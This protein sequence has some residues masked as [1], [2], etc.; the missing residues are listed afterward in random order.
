MKKILLILF[1]LCSVHAYS[2]TISYGISGGPNFTNFPGNGTLNLS[3]SN[4]YITGFHV[5]G[6]LD[7]KFQSFS[8]QP[9]ILFTTTGGEGK[10]YFYNGSNG[11]TDYV[12]NKIVLDYIEVP[13]NFLYRI[14][15]DNGSVFLGGG[16]YFSF[17]V[18][19]KISYAINKDYGTTDN[20]SFGNDSSD[21]NVLDFGV[22]TLEGYQFDS[23][24][25]I[26]GGYGFG[27]TNVYHSG[28]DNKNKGFTVSIGYFFK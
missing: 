17:G 14:K 25:V 18:S 28:P 1:I 8:L 11:V 10:V 4:D 19:G 21:I 2:Q 22:N 6:L 9:G 7:I 24:F 13:I 16:P 20:L 26:S 12:I 27:L 3:P 5:G 15:T 23:G